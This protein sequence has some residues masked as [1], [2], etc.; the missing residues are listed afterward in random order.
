MNNCFTFSPKSYIPNPDNRSGNFN[1]H[2]YE[3][4][5]KFD[6]DEEYKIALYIDKLPNVS[7]WIRNIDKDSLNS[8]WLQTANGKF[9]PDFIINFSN[10]KTVVA[11]YKGKV[12]IPEYEKTKKP[13][14]DAWG[15]LDVNFKFLSL[16]DDNYMSQLDEVGK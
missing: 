15:Q 11:E 14:G 2:K 1:K 3:Y 7:T 9:Y 12:Y 5:H 16:Y 4:V 8:F 6:S 13:V 10:G